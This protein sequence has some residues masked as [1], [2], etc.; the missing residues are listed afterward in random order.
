MRQEDDREAHR[1]GNDVWR[2]RRRPIGRSRLNLQQQ[3]CVAG[4]TKTDAAK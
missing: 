1:D 2:D 4:N 3:I